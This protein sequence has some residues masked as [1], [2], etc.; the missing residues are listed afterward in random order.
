M[1]PFVITPKISTKLHTPKNINLSEKTQNIE[2]QN[3]EKKIVHTFV[4]IKLQSTPSPARFVVP[5]QAMNSF[6]KLKG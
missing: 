2:I 1:T 4:C 3:I 5:A 6:S